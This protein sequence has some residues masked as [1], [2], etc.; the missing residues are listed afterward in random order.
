M[1]DVGIR[2]TTMIVDNEDQIL[3]V[4]AGR[5]ASASQ[6][7]WHATVAQFRGDGQDLMVRE[8]I[9][10]QDLSVG[11]SNRVVTGRSFKLRSVDAATVMCIQCHRRH[12]PSV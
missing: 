11:H 10:G 8:F 7:E 12:C 2:T 1:T 4:L 9:V 5:A 6:E 3:A